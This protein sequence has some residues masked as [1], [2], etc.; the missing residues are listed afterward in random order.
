MKFVPLRQLIKSKVKGNEALEFLVDNIKDE[1]I[2]DSIE[3]FL[4]K[5]VK[6]E[7]KTIPEGGEKVQS[8]ASPKIRQEVKADADKILAANPE[9][10]NTKKIVTNQ[11]SPTPTN[12]K[13]AATK[14]K[15]TPT[16]TK[17]PTPYRRGNFS[18]KDEATA[19]MWD[20]EM[21]DNAAGEK[22]TTQKKTPEKT[23]TAEKTKTSDKETPTEKTKKPKEDFT[24]FGSFHPDAQKIITDIKNSVFKNHGHSEMKGRAAAI[25]QALKNEG[26]DENGKYHKHMHKGLEDDLYSIAHKAHSINEGV[27]NPGSMSENDHIN[28]QK[29]LAKHIRDFYRKLNII[30]AA[31]GLSQNS[32]NAFTFL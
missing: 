12:N 20:K 29:E 25:A 18:F 1:F 13:I 23:V 8:L 28:E 26:L 27:T 9:K 2:A 31:G 10:V 24:S 32:K 6:K 14:I 5:A 11:E 17:T 4:I 30:Q 21:A 7:K 3:E 19:D 16:A 22:K 15:E